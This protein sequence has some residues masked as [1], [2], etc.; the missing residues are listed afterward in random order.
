M[1][2]ATKIEYSANKLQVIS[3][4]HSSYVVP[5]QSAEGHKLHMKYTKVR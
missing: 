4:S 5:N 2:N 1:K 3:E